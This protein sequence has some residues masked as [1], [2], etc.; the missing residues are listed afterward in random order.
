[1]S[2]GL[3]ER[4][5]RLFPDAAQAELLANEG[6]GLLL[7]RLLEDG[8]GDDLTWLTATLPEQELA[9]WFATSG[10]RK[11]SRRSRAY[12]SLVLGLSPGPVS[13]TAAALWPLA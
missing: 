9:R 6:R 8:D 5:A 1:M 2:G 11:L 3:P 13:E 10:G 12:W 7:A 4:T